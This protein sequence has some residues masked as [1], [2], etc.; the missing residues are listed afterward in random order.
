MFLPNISTAGDY[1]L[2]GD[3]PISIKYNHDYETDTR[4][5]VYSIRF[6]GRLIQAML[7]GFD[8]IKIEIGAKGN[9]DYKYFGAPLL[10]VPDAVEVANVGFVQG[11]SEAIQE[12]TA[13]NAMITSVVQISELLPDDIV[14]F[15]GN[16]TLTNANYR[17]FID[18]VT[19]VTT[20]AGADSSQ[21]I[22]TATTDSFNDGNFSAL[23]YELF[24]SFGIFPGDVATVSFPI[25]KEQESQEG[26]QQIS[27]TVGDKL[28]QN[29]QFSAY[30]DNFF[31]KN[32][33]GNKLTVST[34]QVNPE[35][36]RYDTQ[37]TAAALEES[38]VTTLAATTRML[39]K[40]SLMKSGIVAQSKSFTF[41][42]SALFTAATAGVT[43]VACGLKVHAPIEALHDDVEITNN[44]ELPVTIRV[45]SF[46]PQEKS[47]SRV[48]IST[49]LVIQP[50]ETLS[51]PGDVIFFDGQQ[52][53]AYV[54]QGSKYIPGAAGID[55][56][57]AVLTPPTMASPVPTPTNLNFKI[58]PAS[59]TDSVQILLAGLPSSEYSAMIYRSTVGSPGSES[60]DIFVGRI[61]FNSP[62]ITDKNT[63]V[64]TQ[65]VYEAKLLLNGAT[66]GQSVTCLF[67]KSSAGDFSRLTFSITDQSTELAGSGFVHK[68]KIKENI[69]T[70]TASELLSTVGASGQSGLFSA[71]IEASK[72]DTTVV[73]QYRIVKRNLLTNSYSYDDRVYYAGEVLSFSVTQGLASYEYLIF[74]QITTTSAVSY[75]TVVEDTDTS[76]GNTYK[77][78]Y[79]KF[80]DPNANC[81]EVL[82]STKEV[83]ED[84][85]EINLR[86]APRGSFQAA[87][88]GAQIKK[89]ETTILSAHV[90]VEYNHTI[91]RWQYVGKESLV[92]Y[93]VVMAT[94]N[95]T[96]APVGF[97]L[98]Q[99]SPT[100][101]IDMGL[102]HGDH[103][104]IGWPPMP[105]S[106]H[107]HTHVSENSF[108]DTVMG[109]SLG[110]VTYTVFPVM[111]TGEP[112]FE[113]N[114]FKVNFTDTYPL[115]A[116]RS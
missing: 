80:R 68:F 109:A 52:S 19:Q 83:L 99:E 8:T 53:R 78:R 27:K 45:H 61:Y 35:Y 113:S 101:S 104:D 38:E 75:L 91:L 60:Q 28:R 15:I 12:Y 77:Y 82:P 9:L 44:E 90:N 103:D 96:K 5:I 42:S 65:Y 56:P 25:L 43:N 57:L 88:F 87:S 85:I 1:F 7:A 111:T 23:T 31:F 16:G 2:L 100:V 33:G 72:V 47:I 66:T 71:E 63:I 29:A 21:E 55:T 18:Q 105:E 37:I 102:D 84:N 94:Y 74:P 46:R 107:I 76:T 22:S 93:F 20:Q 3:A 110:E 11:V 92:L 40:F 49:P 36:V 81:G 14:A 106:S 51:V 10:A 64:D 26:I 30:Y 41:D 86:N 95:G 62:T 24:D 97:V 32:I 39:L 115:A 114:L 112:G 59:T 6:Y 54:V 98:P 69:E 70:T 4:T 50:G 89:G 17:N 116:L 67:L 73:T 58:N 79:K 108:C 48:E 13:Q 34:S